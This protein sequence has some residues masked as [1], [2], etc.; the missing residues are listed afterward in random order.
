M[1]QKPTGTA[2]VGQPLCNLARLGQIPQVPGG[3]GVLGKEHSSKE[4]AEVL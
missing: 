1:R 4:P 2:A 3:P